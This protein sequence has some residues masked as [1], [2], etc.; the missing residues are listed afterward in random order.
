MHWAIKVIC[1]CFVM[2]ACVSLFID[3]IS[4]RSREQFAAASDAPTSFLVDRILSQFSPDV[5][6]RDVWTS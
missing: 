5:L 2:L 6:T 4:F 1:L 3:P